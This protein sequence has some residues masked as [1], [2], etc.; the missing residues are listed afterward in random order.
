MTSAIATYGLDW[1]LPLPG[2]RPCNFPT[3]KAY[4]EERP[5]KSDSPKQLGRFQLVHSNNQRE[6]A[7]QFKRLECRF[8]VAQGSLR[9]VHLPAVA[10]LTN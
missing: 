6:P 10:I 3:R 7:E 9:T 4:S 8:R 2:A 1:P 5:V